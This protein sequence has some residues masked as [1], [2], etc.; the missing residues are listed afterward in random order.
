MKRDDGPADTTM[1][2]IVHDALRRDLERLRAALDVEPPVDRRRALAAHV[3]WM[4]RFLEA[5]H[6]GEDAGLYPA[7][8]AADPEAGGLLDAMDAEHRA[9][10]PAMET[11]ETCA[12]LWGESGEGRTA[13]LTAIDDLADVLLPHLDRE[14]AEAMPLVSATLT[15][16]Q[17]TEWDQ[18]YNIAPKSLAALGEEGNWVLDGLDG[19]RRQ[20][21]LGLVPLVPRLIV[22]YVFGP[23]Y[24]RRARARWGSSLGVR[25][26]ETGAERPPRPTDQQ[27]H[28][29]PA[30]EG[31]VAGP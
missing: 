12:A 13:L 26:L 21:V 6:S 20:V 8:R 31:G 17:W 2:G 9:I 25:S 11:V 24:R 22:L 28:Q 27:M 23:R 29:G 15:Q 19:E 30:E 10:H 7:V 4:M 1:M 3:G 14:E 16:R 18:R 5:H